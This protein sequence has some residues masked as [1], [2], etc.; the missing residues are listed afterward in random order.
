VFGTAAT[1]EAFIL[2]LKK[3]LNL[4]LRIVFV[5]SDLG[6]SVTKYDPNYK[7]FKRPAPIY[8]SSNSAFN[9]LALCYASDFSAG[10][11]EDRKGKEWKINVMCLEPT[12]TNFLEPQFAT[13][14]NP[15]IV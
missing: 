10:L 12:R 7:Y 6:R 5:Y 11:G 8:R 13:S 14:T 9:M 2:L 15:N 1:T 4:A 3:S